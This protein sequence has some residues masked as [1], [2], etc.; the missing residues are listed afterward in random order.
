MWQTDPGEVPERVRTHTLASGRPRLSL[1][2]VFSLFGLLVICAWA[3][4]GTEVSLVELVTSSPNMWRLLTRMWPP[5]GA[6]YT[7]YDR[8]IEPTLVTIQLALSSTIIAVILALPL[9]LLAAR[10]LV[11]PFVYQS[12]RVVLNILRSIPELVHRP[13]N[14]DGLSEGRRGG[15]R[16]A[17]THQ[18]Y[19]DDVRVYGLIFVS[20][21]GLGPFAG[22]LAL[23]AGSVG[24][25]AKVFAESIEAINPK[26]SGGDGGGGCLAAPTDCLCR[27]FPSPTQPRQLHLALLGT[28]YAGLV[29]RRGHRRR[30]FGF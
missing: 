19:S 7:N 12:V 6:F 9:S 27:F 28:Q 21:V 16:A 20:A 29:H 11:P 10:N 14:S 3:Y 22:P 23:V 8:V 15:S 1:Q 25:I 26:A 18:I 30:W 5:D 2:T 24:S 4:H 17:S 13:S